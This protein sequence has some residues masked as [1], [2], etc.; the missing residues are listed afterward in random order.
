MPPGDT[1]WL[2]TDMDFTTDRGRVA[3]S[4]DGRRWTGLGGDFPLAFAWRTGTF[5]GEQFALFCYAPGA[6]KGWVDI[7]SFRLSALTPAGRVRK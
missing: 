4:M 1:M 3:Y 7:D 6:S 2:R 5:Q